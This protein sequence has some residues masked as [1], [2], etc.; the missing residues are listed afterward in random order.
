LSG[1]RFVPSATKPTLALIVM[2]TAAVVEAL[3]SLVKY[4]TVRTVTA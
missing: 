4:A 2:V 3:L 1:S